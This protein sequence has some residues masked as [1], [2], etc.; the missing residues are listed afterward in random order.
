MFEI[1]D[2]VL[3]ITTPKDDGL[4]KCSDK[5]MHREAH[6]QTKLKNKSNW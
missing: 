4:K 3:A 6:Y 5:V 1:N 2:S